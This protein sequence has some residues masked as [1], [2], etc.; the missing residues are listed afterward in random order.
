LQTLEFMA[1]HMDQFLRLTLRHLEIVAISVSIAVV[2]GILIGIYMTYNKYLA[3]VMLALAGIIITIPGIA[4]LGM[5]IP[6]LGIGMVPSITALVFY[7]QL[8]ILRNTYTGITGVD[9]AILEAGRGMGMTEGQLMWRVKLPLALPVIIA[10]V[11]TSIVM[12]VG[13]AALA[14]AIGAGGLGKYIF[15][16]I[17]R[18]YNPMVLA[19]AIGV[20]VIAIVLDLVLQRVE[21]RLVSAGLSSGSEVAQA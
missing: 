1:T 13:L 7:G 10:G 9:K 12:N 6:L 11:R 17:A 15:Q 3:Q 2:I 16:G 18:T 14:A 19:G 5:L 20:S 21:N 4:M 8:P